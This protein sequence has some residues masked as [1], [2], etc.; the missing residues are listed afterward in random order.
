LGDFE[1]A[2]LTPIP[3]G[4][5]VVSLSAILMNDEYYEFARNNAE[6]VDG[7]HL[8]N[9]PALI[10]LKAKAF[11]DIKGRLERQE[12]KAHNEKNKLIEDYKKHR[13]DIIRIALILTEED[14]TKLKGSI[15]QDILLY[16][17]AVKADPP[18]YKQLAKNF[19]IPEINLHEVFKQLEATFGL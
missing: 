13:A 16:L 2:H 10:C 14:K 5:E 3:L 11:L 7:L 4:E 19:E 18:D 8:L 9:A 1:G 17:E 12:W 6:I 15:K